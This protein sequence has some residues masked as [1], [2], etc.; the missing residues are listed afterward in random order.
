M[1]WHALADTKSVAT[2]DPALVLQLLAF[3]VPFGL[4]GAV[5][6]AMR[7][8]SVIV[9]LLKVTSGRVEALSSPSEIEP[10]HAPT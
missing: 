8:V 3:V 7:P 6:P 9:G 2:Y 10:I 5:S 4:A 1:R